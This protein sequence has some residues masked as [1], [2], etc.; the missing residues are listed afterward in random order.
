MLEVDLADAS[1]RPRLIAVDDRLPLLDPANINGLASMRP[2]LIA[3]DDGTAGRERP[4][5]RGASMRPRLI[6]VDDPLDALVTAAPQRTAS[7]RPRLIAVDDL[8]CP[9]RLFYELQLQ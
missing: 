5:A 7:M 8:L 2:R 1:M 6:A 9:L 3:V 4:K